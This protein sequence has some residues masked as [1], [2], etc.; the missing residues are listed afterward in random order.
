MSDE[1]RPH[2]SRTH[3]ELTEDDHHIERSSG[4]D[5]VIGATQSAETKSADTTALPHRTCEE[6]GLKIQSGN[7]GNKCKL[8]EDS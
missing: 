3:Q 1:R 4:P 8:C 7:D 2:D 6:C 5:I